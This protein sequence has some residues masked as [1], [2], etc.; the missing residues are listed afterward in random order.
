[1]IKKLIF[2]A[3]ALALM[4]VFIGCG[5]MPRNAVATVKGNVITMNDLDEQIDL[6]IKSSGATMP[7]K[8][9][10]EYK[11]L[12]R[13]V[14][15]YLIADRIFALEAEE[16]DISV[17]DEEVDE[18]INQMKEQSGG[19]E[20]FQ[21]QLDAMNATIDQIMERVRYDLLFRKVQAE[22]N[23]DAPKVPDEEV[24]AYYDE[25][26]ADYTNEEETR[27]VKHILVKTEEEANQVKE[28]LVAGEDFATLASELSLDTGSAGM[29]G[30]LPQPVT[31]TNSGL[32]PEFEAAMAQLKEGE[33]SGPVQTTYGFHIIVVERIIPPGP[34]P[35]D[36]VKEQIRQQIQTLQYDY[37]YF[38]EWFEEAKVRY[39]VEYS[40]GFEPVTEETGTGTSTAT[41]G[42]ASQPT[43]PEPAQ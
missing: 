11:N 27:Q 26:I 36:A 7:E 23:K 16:R 30:L 35:F 41:S 37:D 25:N 18:Q 43:A 2:I 14:L 1:M 15:E 22:V 24:R 33:V 21:Q 12:Q 13:E 5:G 9:S 6:Y 8:D 32:V 39:E 3:C 17:T 42:E 29:G 40:E 19:E 34:T 10:E 4:P 38:R 20:V 28:R 31:A